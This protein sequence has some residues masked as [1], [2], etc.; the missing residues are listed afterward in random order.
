[1]IR[2]LIFII[3]VVFFA[4]LLTLLLSV[5]SAVSAEA[6]GW[7]FDLPAGVAASL[8][9]GL[10]AILIGATALLKDA[11]GAAKS[12]RA[13]K[14]IARR[15][16]GL[17]A[18]T[19]GLE[20][21]A[22]GDGPAA[23]RQ[24]ELAA[25]AL[26]GAAVTKLLTAQAAQLS[27]DNI[28]AGEALASMLEAPETEFLA[29]RGLYAKAMR[30]NDGAAALAHATRAFELHPKAR[31]A[32][33]AVFDLALD[34]DDFAAA[35][36]AVMRAA[37]AK[38][39]DADRAD[40]GAA[41]AATAAAFA[42][43]AAGDDAAARAGA[44]VA[45]KLAPDFAP[46]A[47]L[48]AK[49]HAERGEARKAAK[50]LGDA[51]AIAPERAIADAYDRIAAS[52]P[53][54]ARADALDR[55]ADRNPASHEADLLRARANLIRGDAAGAASILANLLKSSATARALYQMA[56]AQGALHGEASAHVWLVRAAA[57]PRE[58]TP[59]PDTFF[60]MTGDGWRRLIRDYFEHARLAPPPLE[61][62]PPGLAERE[63][64]LLEAPREPAAAEEGANI[65]LPSGGEAVDDAATDETLDRDA[66]AARDVS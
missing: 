39:I 62:P 33:E 24:A 28:A 11:F 43:H 36:E 31:W 7:R 13:R 48:A 61:P 38:A 26:G 18:M 37:K 35:K 51:F 45:L 41:A 55:L 10:A 15:E 46:A 54:A 59:D 20:A 30:D 56:E 64:A 8:A 57:A 32:F 17:A 49:L 6:F 22:A 47:V 14:A 50:I 60:R 21:L 12:A 5:R 16:R 53:P 34:R 23:R 27:G 9:I 4:A 52:D 2:V 40:R 25:K 63:I 44:A 29:L 1:M 42:A 66:V 58:P 19:K 3:W 65:D